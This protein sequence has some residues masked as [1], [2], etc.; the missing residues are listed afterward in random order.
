A[1]YE[2]TMKLF[3]ELEIKRNEREAKEM[4]GKK[5]QSEEE[6]ETQEKAKREKEWQKNFE[7]S[8]DDRV[9]SWRNFQANT[10]GEKGK[11][12]W[13]CLQPPKV[14]MEQ[15]PYKIMQIK[16]FKSSGSL[17]N[18]RETAQAIKGMHIRKA[19][20]YLKDASLEINHLMLGS[21]E[22]CT[23]GNENFPE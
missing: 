23:D 16:R 12:N 4:H 3:A 5:R 21:K 14:K 1:V 20:K 13:T 9:D 19:T 11:K 7:E 6:I 17:K 10:K 22:K 2:Q 15:K 8:W 18:T